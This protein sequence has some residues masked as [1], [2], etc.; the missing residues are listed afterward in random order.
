VP[1]SRPGRGAPER[2]PR[3]GTDADLPA[4]AA[5][6]DEPPSSSPEAA[7]GGGRRGRRPARATAWTPRRAWLSA[8]AALLL[9]A[10]LD[11]EALH[12]TAESQPFGW[13][14]D[15]ATALA[16]PLVEVS[17]AL[18]L[19]EPRHWLEDALDRPSTRP[20]A[21]PSTSPTTERPTTTEPP[22]SETTEPTTATTEPARRT[23]TAED[24]LR[25]LVAGDSM[26]EALGPVL[27]EL[28]E[29]TG[30]V[31]AERALEYSSGLTRP[32][33]FDWPAHLAALLDEHD[34]EVVV[35]SVGA[36]DAQGIQTPAGSASFGTGAWVAEYRA[37]VA[38]TMDLLAAEDRIVYWLG[39]PVMRSADFDARMALITSIFRD[40]AQGRPGI[41]FVDTRPT[42]AGDDGGYTAY[43]P[44][45]SGTPVLVRRDD[46]IHLTPAGARRLA[47][48]LM[49]SVR[50]DW[51]IP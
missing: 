35:V 14:Y 21:T 8:L 26:T 27:E 24:P 13:R 12:D 1:G 7:S 31:A 5:S 16:D 34:P 22:T 19:T 9:A 44:D 50:A 4:T 25:L 23:P 10:L 11:A 32:D 36:N 37:R 38:S 33:F 41:R 48:Q 20:E 28:A 51:P 43:L 49:H 15:V 3:H 46:G 18:H 6:G 2:T 47:A 42:F 45:A 39:E 17:R 29:E 40:E 30:V